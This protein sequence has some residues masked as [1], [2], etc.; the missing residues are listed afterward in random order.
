MATNSK[1]PL[2]VVPEELKY[3]EVI[4]KQ[5]MTIYNPFEISLKYKSKFQFVLYFSNVLTPRQC[6][7]F[8]F[9]F[10]SLVLCTSPQKYRVVESQGT[11]RSQCCVDVYV[12]I[13]RAYSICTT[14]LYNGYI[15]IIFI[16]FI[17]TR[18]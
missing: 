12:Y 10:F 5:V 8:K 17:Y 14:T 15:R 3:N 9:C 7:H 16:L 1:L 11:L 6:G 13:N 2:F 4:N 18:S